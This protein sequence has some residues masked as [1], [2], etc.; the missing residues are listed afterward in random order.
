MKQEIAREIW[1]I[2]S[3]S[4]ISRNPEDTMRLSLNLLNHK[5]LAALLWVA[6]CLVV[7]LAFIPIIPACFERAPPRFFRIPPLLVGT[8][9]RPYKNGHD[10]GFLPVCHRRHDRRSRS[11]IWHPT[12]AYLKLNRIAM[13]P[14]ASR[15]GEL[16]I[17]T[18]TFLWKVAVHIPPILFSLAGPSAV[19]TFQYQALLDGI[20]IFYSRNRRVSSSVSHYSNANSAKQR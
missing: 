19:R 2:S 5:L 16:L 3:L 15:C 14:R 10:I 20:A 11:G 12:R 17:T 4:S 7:A 1:L 8:E 13:L 18:E 9:E 6:S